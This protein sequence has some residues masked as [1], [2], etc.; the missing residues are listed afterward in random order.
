MFFFAGTQYKVLNSKPPETYQMVRGVWVHSFHKD[1]LQALRGPRFE[2][3]EPKPISHRSFRVDGGGN[4]A[5]SA[6]LTGNDQ[7]KTGT[8]RHVKQNA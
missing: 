3:Q 4:F 1:P 7:G 8:F 5:T 6:C 2:I